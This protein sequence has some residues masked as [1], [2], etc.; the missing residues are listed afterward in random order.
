MLCE[1]ETSL[2][3]SQHQI[4]VVLEG[5][6][7]VLA[8]YCLCLH[9]IRFSGAWG[10]NGSLWQF[11]CCSSCLERGRYLPSCCL[12]FSIIEIV[13][14]N[15]KTKTIHFGGIKGQVILQRYVDMTYDTMYKDGN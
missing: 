1:T 11:S 4:L 5:S 8:Y 12:W 9:W 10:G 7:E 6:A 15:P 2:S 13:K 3:R 14:D